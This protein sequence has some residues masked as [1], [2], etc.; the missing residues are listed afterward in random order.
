M[1]T[2][3]TETRVES[4]QRRPI[5]RLEAV[6][7][8]DV[9]AFSVWFAKEDPAFVASAAARMIDGLLPR[10]GKQY[11]REPAAM[12][13]AAGS[14][15]H[16]RTKVESTLFEDGG[17]NVLYAGLAG[18]DDDDDGHSDRELHTR[19]GLLLGATLLDRIASE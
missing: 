3:L 12:R 6:V 17:G 14:K 13:A 5:A 18:G 4:G 7:G 9:E 16:A 1:P 19:M 11:P 2:M 8:K 15:P 10:R